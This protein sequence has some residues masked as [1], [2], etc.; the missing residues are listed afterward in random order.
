MGRDCME[1][2]GPKGQVRSDGTDIGCSDELGKMVI[3]DQ[4]DSTGYS[5]PLDKHVPL[6]I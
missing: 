1:G 4:A 3:V 6:P 5:T 2:F